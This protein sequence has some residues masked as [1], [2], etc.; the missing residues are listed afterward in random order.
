MPRDFLD[1]FGSSHAFD[2]AK[3]LVSEW[4][5]ADLL[6]QLTDQELSRESAFSRY[7]GAGRAA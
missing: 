5:T 6:F 1:L 3:A 7:L 4:K 2:P